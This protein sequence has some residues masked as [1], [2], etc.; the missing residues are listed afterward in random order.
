[1]DQR[2]YTIFIPEFIAAGSALAIIGLELFFPKI[3]RDI[4]AYLTALAALAWGIAG[5]FYIGK[6]PNN[7]QGLVQS[8]NYTTFFRL[9]AA[10]IV[11]VTALMSAS[12]MRERTKTAAEYYGLLLL[13]GCGLVYMAAA[14]ELITAYISL[15]LLSFC[16]Y[17]LVG[18]LKR[19]SLSS[20]ASLKYILLGAFSSAMLLY[21]I[22]IIYGVTNSTGYDQIAVQ[23]AQRSG[24]TD[25]AVIVG[26]VL[27]LA[28]VGFKVSA[29][30]FHMW[31]PDAY[32][33]APLPITGFLST[34][35]KAAGFALFVR[36][37]TA[38][39]QVDAPEWRWAV[40]FLAAATMV[41]GNLI[42]IQQSS[43]KRLVAYSSIGQVGYMLVVI[44]AIGY[45][46]QELGRNASSA[47]LLHI[48]GYVVSTLALFAALTAYYNRTGKDTIV[49][50]RGLA[51]TQPLLAMVIT[52]S[53]FS[54]AGLPFFAGFA[55]KLIMFQS[56]TTDGLLWLVGLAVVNSFISLYYYLMVIRQMY[57][58]EP[59]GGLTRFRPSPLLGALAGVLMLGVVFIGVYPTALYKAA[60][61][62]T[63]TLYQQAPTG[64]VQ[65]P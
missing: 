22:S 38:A 5:A 19:D 30:P 39:F 29:A 10:S 54:F 18:F 31:A 36:L 47:L 8:D 50:L 42:A 46:D 48:G 64:A 16:L 32:E 23:L 24:D 65:A 58:F 44:A 9:L 34:L 52:V 14:R 2:D 49:G 26:F 41:I 37:F 21:G 11:F 15:E 27:I 7:F 56:A 35:S 4:P 28:G 55:T 62:A 6:D 45:G 1:M 25:G 13:A 61:R 12:Y 43:L 53:L 63:E 20:E 51:E 57:L 33:G 40:A 60:D 17:I 3:R 59:E